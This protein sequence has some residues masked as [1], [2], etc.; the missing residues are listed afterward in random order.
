[1]LHGRF[2]VAAGA[3]NAATGAPVAAAAHALAASAVG[4]AAVAAAVPAAAVA[5]TTVATARA[6]AAVAA[7]V[8]TTP[9]AAAA[10]HA[11]AAVAAVARLRALLDG[12]ART[13]RYAGIQ[14]PDGVRAVLPEAYGDAR[15]DSVARAE[16]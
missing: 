7:T 8:A 1:M 16:Q 12:Y 5:A 6:A 3:A 14:R 4:T 10:L 15:G 13:Q 11:A 9:I 2:S